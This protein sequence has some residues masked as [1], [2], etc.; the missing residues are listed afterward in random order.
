MPNS[1]K[2]KSTMN[3]RAL[4]VFVGA[5]LCAL[6]PQASAEIPLVKAKGWDLSL[7]GR[8]NSFLS[9]ATGDS[10]YATTGVPQWQGFYDYADA[11][12]NQTTSRV[13]T[14]FVQNVL[15]FTLKKPFGGDNDLKVRFAPW[16]G[17]SQNR[18]SIDYPAVDVREVYFKVEGQWGGILVGRDLSL[19][20]RGAIL[21]DYDIEHNY[22]LGSPCSLGTVQGGACGHAGFG[23]LFPGFNAGIVYNTPEIAGLQLSV[24][25]YDPS[26]ISERSYDRTPYP[27]MMGELTFK[28]P[29]Y[30]T[31]SVSGQW[32]RLGHDAPTF[33]NADAI[34]VAGSAG[35]NV[36]PVQV[37]AGGFYA[38]G[39]GI[40]APL[41][42]YPL[43]ADDSGVLRHQQGILGLAS[44]SFGNTKIAGG[45]GVTQILKTPNDREPFGS[46]ANPAGS[47]GGTFVKSQFGASV[48][49]YQHIN[50]SLVV[51]LE[52]FRAAYSWYSEVD[53]KDMTMVI[54][55]VQTVNLINVGGT[56]VF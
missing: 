16:V 35:V 45:V 47:T 18:S 2:A 33:Q 46:P 10:P 40:Y 41:E 51:A 9:F 55:P 53:P 24:G 48:G 42:N 27:R 44:V 28:V 21:L 7:D 52:Y 34:G 8:V 13:R 15:G 11:S 1:R 17:V 39:G 23:I 6:A 29:K 38:Q 4:G 22:G 36:G 26:A 19:F 30:F 54:S 37:G 56:V 49:L 14:G 25:M 20:S 5:A 32:E 3:K 50:E 31:A 43:F 12:N